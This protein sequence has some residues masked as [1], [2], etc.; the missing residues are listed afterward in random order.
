MIFCRFCGQQVL[1]LAVAAEG[2]ALYN[3]FI[4]SI[5]LAQRRKRITFQSDHKENE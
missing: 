5:S 3:T 2:K 1:E 4:S